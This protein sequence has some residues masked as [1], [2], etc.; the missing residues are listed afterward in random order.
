M[1]GSQQ[2]QQPPKV[3]AK[4]GIYSLFEKLAIM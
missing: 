3:E 4:R 2:N 1:S